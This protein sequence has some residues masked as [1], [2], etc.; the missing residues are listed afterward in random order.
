MSSVR[1]DGNV[2]SLFAEMFEEEF[3]MAA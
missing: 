1:F 3:Q 2:D